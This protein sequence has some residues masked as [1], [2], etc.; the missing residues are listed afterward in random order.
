LK[1]SSDFDIKV[2]LLD[3]TFT[4]LDTGLYKL[5]LSVGNTNDPIVT[6]IM[7]TKFKQNISLLNLSFQIKKSIVIGGFKVIITNVPGIWRRFVT[8]SF[9]CG[10]VLEL[11]MNSVGSKNDPGEQTVI[12]LAENPFEVDRLYN[13]ILD[14]D[15]VNFDNTSYI[16]N[17]SVLC[18]TKNTYK[19]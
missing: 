19:L 9:E 7:E 1:I 4:L 3:L 17:S 6:E 10:I 2:N 16:N 18:L 5:Y 13:I 11:F 15:Y 12:L 14:T 8:Q